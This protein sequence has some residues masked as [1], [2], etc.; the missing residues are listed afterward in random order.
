MGAQGVRQATEVAI[1][2][3]N[4][5]PSAWVKPSS[6]VQRCNAMAHE[7]I[8]DIRPLKVASGIT[9]RRRRPSPALELASCADHVSP[10]SAP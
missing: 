10:V 4:Y 2:N 5:L 7:C 8:I 3:A 6:A 9:A 1:L